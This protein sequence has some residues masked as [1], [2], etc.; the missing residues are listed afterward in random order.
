MNRYT[1][2]C[3]SG[4][5]FD[6]NHNKSDIPIVI[7]QDQLGYVDQVIIRSKFYVPTGKRGSSIS[8]PHLTSQE[9]RSIENGTDARLWLSDDHSTIWLD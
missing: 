3:F 9:Y 8:E 1:I 2:R 5:V 7:S 6:Q 4:I